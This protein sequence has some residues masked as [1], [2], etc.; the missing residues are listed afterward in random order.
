MIEDIFLKKIH[1]NNNNKYAEKKIGM[2]VFTIITFVLVSMGWLIFMAPNMDVV[3]GMIKQTNVL[4]IANGLSNVGMSKYDWIVLVVAL[5]VMLIVDFAHEKG[6]S[7]F[8]IINKQ[9]RLIRYLV[10]VNLIWV[11]IIFGVYGG[12]YDASKFIYFQF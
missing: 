3:F 1:L 12:Q 7:I 5:L 2:F 8:G 6:K 11:V 4:G 10:Y 9:P